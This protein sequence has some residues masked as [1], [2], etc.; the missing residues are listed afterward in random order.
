MKSAGFMVLKSPDVP[1]VLIELGY[2]SNKEDLK[3]MLSP[4]WRNRAAGTHREGG[5][6]VFRHAG[7]RERGGETQAI[8]PYLK[9]QVRALSPGP[10]FDHKNGA[11]RSYQRHGRD[12]VRS[13]RISQNPAIRNAAGGGAA[14]RSASRQMVFST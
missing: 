1:S 6:R 8:V 2:V 12:R 7:R 3:A 14:I 5:R 10:Q 4:E 13:C 9:A 11:T